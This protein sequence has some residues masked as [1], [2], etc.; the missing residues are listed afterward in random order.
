M[1]NRID[2][3][4]ARQSIDKKDSIS[5]ESQIE[6]CKYEL[7]GGSCKEYQDKGYSGKNTD[8]PQFQMLVEDI[9]RGLIARV[10]VY[11]LDRISRS[12]L[13]FANMMVLFQEYNVEFISSTEKFDTSTPMGRAM[14]NICIVFA[15][16]ERETIQKRVQDAWYARCQR[17]FKMGGRAPYGFRTE[18][19]IIDGIHTKKLVIE[20]TEA[21]FVRKMYEM[22]IDP[23]VSLHDITRQ[24]TEQGMRTYFGK[25]FSRA[26]ISIML[27]VIISDTD[28]TF[29]FVVSILYTQ[30]FNLLCDKADDEY[31]GRLPVHVRC[32]LDEFANIGQIPKFEKLI[33]TIRSR[34]ISASIILQSQSQLKAIY[35]DNADT[36]VGNCDTTLFLGGK[37]KTTLKEISEILGKETIDS[38]NTSEIRGRELSHGLNYQKLGKQLMT[39]DEIA[40]MDGGK[41]ILQLRGVRP[42]FSD[43]FDI[44]KHPKYKYLHDTRPHFPAQYTAA[45]AAPL[46]TEYRRTAELTQRGDSRLYQRAVFLCGGIC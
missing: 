23:Q 38:F 18:P 33:A 14:L 29:N 19:I 1:N 17:G 4:Y 3:I 44:T 13:D 15:Q 41:C 22:Y 16:L 46:T 2:A 25:P 5:I 43:K 28:D 30:L 9:K 40:V 8:R 35:K 32:L 34:E 11:K 37:E 24:L 36:I 20:P 21:A 42:F 6:F 7:R 10:V 39:E 12:I 45:G 31:G 26:T 27:F